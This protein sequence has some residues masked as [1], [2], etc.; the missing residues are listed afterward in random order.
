[1][2]SRNFAVTIRKSRMFDCLPEAVRIERN[3]LHQTE[4]VMGTLERLPRLIDSLKR[5]KKTVRYISELDRQIESRKHSIQAEMTEAE[6]WIR[7]KMMRLLNAR[8]ASHLS[9]KSIL[10][11]SRRLIIDR[12]FDAK[13]GWSLNR[14][15]LE[16]AL[17]A[18]VEAAEALA[19]FGMDP[20][21]AGWIRLDY[22]SFYADVRP[23]IANSEP[24]DRCQ[25]FASAPEEEQLIEA[26]GHGIVGWQVHPSTDA[27]GLV[28]GVIC[29]AGYVHRYS[30]PPAV[31]KVARSRNHQTSVEWERGLFSDDASLYG[32]LSFLC[33]NLSYEPLS[34]P[35]QRQ[36]QSW[37]DVDEI[38]AQATVGYYMSSFKAR[39]ETEHPITRK[40]LLK[41]VDV[42]LGMVAAWIVNRE[43]IKGPALKA[44]RS[45]EAD[46][47]CTDELR[48]YL[49]SL[50]GEERRVFTYRGAF[51]YVKARASALGKGREFEDAITLTMVK[52][53]VG[54]K[55]KTSLAQCGISWRPVG[56]RP[57]KKAKLPVQ[58]RRT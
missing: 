1:M 12:F 52:E 37:A 11:K 57:C 39:N 53:R 44:L 38:N 56:G 40:A 33:A 20:K 23:S 2:A 8:W 45:D 42:F 24:G 58:S 51:Q 30:F 55:V 26:L 28:G 29:I 31:E 9:V 34:L 3:L 18:L 36:P 21:F 50:S 7:D 13:E 17:E 54:P 22:R 4:H 32:F 35:L 19:A 46:K 41:K 16:G 6:S 48:R 47:F 5:N 10:E 27:R 25:L 15:F 14:T 43:E 49:Q